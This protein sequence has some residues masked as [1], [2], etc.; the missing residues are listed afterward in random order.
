LYDNS[1]Y[2][3]D[4]P[5]AFLSL[6]GGDPRAPSGHIFDLEAWIISWLDPDYVYTDACHG[7]STFLTI[8]FNS[9]GI[10]ALNR[11][12]IHPS[13]TY[14]NVLP[15]ARLLKSVRMD[16]A[17]SFYDLGEFAFFNHGYV[18]VDGLAYDAT[19]T[20]EKNLSGQAYNQPPKGW[21]HLGFIQTGT[22]SPFY[23]TFKGLTNPDSVQQIL[24][25]V[26]YYDRSFTLR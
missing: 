10:A 1:I 9:M 20:R 13:V 6:A 16:P 4:F 24:N 7:Y 25:T 23:G 3:P 17:G 26:L 19:S 2:A 12:V 22:S 14:P 8:S 21:N 15:T 11:M 5:A 18:V